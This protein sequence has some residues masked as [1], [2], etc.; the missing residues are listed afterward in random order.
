MSIPSLTGS[1]ATYERTGSYTRPSPCNTVSDAFK[2]D[3]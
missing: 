1:D 3:K 2:Y